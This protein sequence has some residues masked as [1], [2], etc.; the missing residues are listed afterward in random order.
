MTA[1]TNLPLNG[2]GN[3]LHQSSSQPDS[4][5]GDGE[6]PRLQRHYLSP[7]GG[8][9]FLRH[10]SSQAVSHVE[11]REPP[12]QQAHYHSPGSAGEDYSHASSLSSQSTESMGAAVDMVG[13]LTHSTEEDYLHSVSNLVKKLWYMVKFPNFNKAG[14]PDEKLFLTY[15]QSYIAIKGS[16]L[17]KSLIPQ[18]KKRATDVLRHRRSAVTLEMKENFFGTYCSRSSLPP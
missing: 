1:T 12:R 10:S 9:K 7:N 2:G 8:G 16:K 13:T 14:S 5:V 3:V 17:F 11:V 15:I 4:R 6:L 18:I